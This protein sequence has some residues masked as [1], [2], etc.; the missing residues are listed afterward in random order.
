MQT[1]Q[2]TIIR[3]GSTLFDEQGRIQGSLDLKLT[4]NGI[5]QNI[6]TAEQL[7]PQSIELIFSSP[8][9]PSLTSALQIG[10]LLGVPVKE[11]PGLHSVHQGLWQGKEFSELKRCSPRVFRQW[12]ESPDSV[13]PPEGEDPEE[14]ILRVYHALKKPIRRGGNFAI[15]VAE[16]LASLVAS[17]LR[18]LPPHLPGPLRAGGQPNR[19][20]VITHQPTPPVPAKTT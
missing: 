16:P 13:C 7:R 3:P 15:V 10:R 11:L 17:I 6:E 2:A 20:E 9:E 12:E 18:D 14:I 4:P 1:F 8:S 5:A 19:I